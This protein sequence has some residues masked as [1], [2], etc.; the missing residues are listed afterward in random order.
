MAYRSFPLRLAM[1]NALSAKW[2]ISPNVVFS[3]AAKVTPKLT[4]T[5]RSKL[6]FAERP[7][8]AFAKSLLFLMTTSSFWVSFKKPIN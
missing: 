2:N 1:Y 5:G 7:R 4:E 8:I 6:Y 3:L